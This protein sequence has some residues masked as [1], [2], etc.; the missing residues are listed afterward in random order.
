MT[1]AERIQS[2]LLNGG[3]F[4]PEMMDHEK[5]GALLLDLREYIKPRPQYSAPFNTRL[6]AWFGG[7]WTIGT[8]YRS[9]NGETWWLEECNA[10]DFHG[11]PDRIEP[12][13]WLPLPE[14]HAA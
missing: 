11:I 13:H 9:V 3:L 6:L 8:R 4:N 1:L 12:T 7:K 14:P 10:S 5:V 2:Y